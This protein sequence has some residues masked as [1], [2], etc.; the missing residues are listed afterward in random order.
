M[1]PRVRAVYS[2][3]GALYTCAVLLGILRTLCLS[4][5][6]TCA[7][8]TLVIGT[9][10]SK[11]VMQGPRGTPD[12]LSFSGGTGDRNEGSGSKPSRRCSRTSAARSIHHAMG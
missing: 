6:A 1:P 12:Q 9:D 11:T 3:V 10:P 8:T 5:L 7:A 4:F 2:R